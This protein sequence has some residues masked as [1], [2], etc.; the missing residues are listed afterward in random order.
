M[1]DAAPPVIPLCHDS[2]LLHELRALQRAARLAGADDRERD[3]ALARLDLLL[4][5]GSESLLEEALQLL[6]GGR[7]LRVTGRPSG[8]VFYQVASAALG[9]RG[10]G[11]GGGGGGGPA[12]AARYDLEASGI[13]AG[14]EGWGAHVYTVLLD[15]PGLCT[16]QRFGEQLAAASG[17]R[18]CRH[19]L[20]ALVADAVA[21]TPYGARAR[22]KE[23][24][25]EEASRALMLALCR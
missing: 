3:E 11:G 7:V 16:C 10:G 14:I 1:D 4:A 20:A 8:R 18:L 5:A 15:G 13:S 12:A 23:P 19:L 22:A 6:E 21:G 25:D 24:P 17:G 2:L 9:A